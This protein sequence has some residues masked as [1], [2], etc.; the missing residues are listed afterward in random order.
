MSF[1]K[2]KGR[3]KIIQFNLGVAAN[4][5]VPDIGEANLCDFVFEFDD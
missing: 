5:N 1:Y 2:W 4:E 3:S